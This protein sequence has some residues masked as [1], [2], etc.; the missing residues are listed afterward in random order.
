MS[1][2]NTKLFLLNMDHIDLWL[3]TEIQQAQII[4]YTY[5]LHKGWIDDLFLKFI[6]TVP[7]S[8]VTYPRAVILCTITGHLIVQN[9]SIIIDLC[10]V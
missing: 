2:Q 7:F 8:Q 9:V 10:T 1:R 6:S 5:Q 3:C 4:R